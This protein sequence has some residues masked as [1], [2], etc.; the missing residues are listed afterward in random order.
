M[1]ASIRL[2]SI[3]GIE[4]GIHYSLFVVLALVSWSLA[5]GF[6]PDEYPGWA[7]VTYWSTGLVCA[8]MLFVSVL[9]HELAHSLVAKA[10]GFRVQGITL[11]ILGGVSN[12]KADAGKA[13]D[14]FVIAVVGPLASLAL[15]AVLWI[16]VISLQDNSTPIA[17]VVWYLALLNLLL[18]VFNMLPA[19]PLDGGRVLRSVVWAITG[20][21]S[22]ATTIASRGGQIVGI[23]LMGL[24][25][26]EVFQG[27]VLQGLWFALI[28]WFL[29]STATGN[30]RQGAFE[31]TARGIKVKDVMEEDPL[32][33]APD[34]SLSDAVYEYLVNR[35]ARSLPVCEGNTLVGII[36]ITDVK[37]VPQHTWSSIRVRD[38]MTPAP[39]RQV[40]PDDDL[41]HALSLLGEH[42]IHQVPVMDGDRL[43]GLLSRAHVIQHLHRRAELGIE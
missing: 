40:R 14:E 33:I 36:T 23:G 24:G 29:H 34:V 19:Y 4:V 20:S 22:K 25:A 18:A 38:A 15:S 41:F 7:T 37:G 35:G 43:V 13:V 8:L 5:S 11:F 9:A 31:D 21:L 17:A 28:G 30:L 12:L 32:T 2:G 39:L 3:A 6:L 10:R 27:F 26:L 16:A 1:K 42:S